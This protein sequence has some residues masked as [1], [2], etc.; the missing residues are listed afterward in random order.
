MQSK[1]F[2]KNISGSNYL[3]NKVASKF[4][5][6]ARIAMSQFVAAQQPYQ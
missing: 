3:F 1:Q 2:S 6:Q 4:G 5:T